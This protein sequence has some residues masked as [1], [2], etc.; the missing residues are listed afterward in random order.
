MYDLLIV[1][2]YDNLVNNIYCCYCD[3]AVVVAVA[4]AEI[5]YPYKVLMSG[6]I[7]LRAYDRKDIINHTLLNLL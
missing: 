3:Y 6:A 5:Q 7:H 4:V 1:Y 2:C